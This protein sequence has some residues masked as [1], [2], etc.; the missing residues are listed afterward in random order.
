MV[1]GIPNYGIGDT[2]LW[3]WGYH[4][5]LKKRDS[6]PI[7]W[8]F[9]LYKIR[10]GINT[11]KMK[12]KNL[13]VR[14]ITEVTNHTDGEV[15][16][17][18]RQEMTMFDKEPPYV[19]FY[20]QD[21]GRLNGLNGAEQKLINELVF[22]MGYNNIVPSYKPV[23]EMIAEKIG[24]AYNTLEA[25]IKELYKKGILIRKARG[26]YI[27]DPHLFG[28]GSWKDVQKIRMVIEYNADGT[29]SINTEVSKQLGL[30]ERV[31]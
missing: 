17:T 10:E 18:T 25:A 16:Q 31:Q 5:F 3:Y 19:K 27:M 11:K 1:L 23:K 6:A 9:C 24:V 2:I 21:I 14:E 8:V 13:Y 7:N 22:N 26:L 29:K 28:R 12:K 4:N 20:L 30:F 15:I